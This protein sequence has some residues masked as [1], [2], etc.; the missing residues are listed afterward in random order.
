MKSFLHIGLPKTGT[1]SLQEW[2]RLN[3]AALAQA[4][5]T[6]VPLLSAHRLAVATLG[7]AL[8]CRSDIVW[9][10][11]Q[12][13]LAQALADAAHDGAII[14]SEYFSLAE[15]RAVRD[16]LQEAGISISKTI[17]YLRRQDIFCAAGYAQDVKAMGAFE[18]VT[19]ASYTDALDWMLLR[20]NWQDVS[21]AVTLLNYDLH[22]HDVI[23]SFSHAIGAQDVPTM[24]MTERLNASLSAELTEVARI[25]NQKQQS[26]DVEVLETV[27]GRHPDIRFGFSPQVTGEFERHYIESNRKLAEIYPE[28][29]SSYAV[30]NWQSPGQDFSGRVS[31]DHVLE[32]VRAVRK[33]EARQSLLR[34]RRILVAL[35]RARKTLLLAQFISGVWG[36]QGIREAAKG[37]LA[38]ATR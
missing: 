34:K 17:A 8:S 13:T 3:S 5:F 36:R 11:S 31:E 30:E 26:F 10:R 35:L 23:N 28:E 38:R 25:L 6:V 15:P 21:E 37:A 2:L 22:K 29:F 16:L 7:E 33:H 12:V 14:S 18:V 27:K 19:D 24:G 9:I 32:I 4:R 1:T 20:E